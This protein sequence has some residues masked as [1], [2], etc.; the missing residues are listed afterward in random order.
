MAFLV[1]EPLHLAPHRLPSEMAFWIA[2]VA[3]YVKQNL[4]MEDFWLN[5]SDL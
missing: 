5:I 2:A 4:S 1:V 3:S